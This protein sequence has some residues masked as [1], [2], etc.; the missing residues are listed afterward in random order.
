MS[1]STRPEKHSRPEKYSRKDNPFLQAQ[2]P[3]LRKPLPRAAH[4][5][6][7]GYSATPSA[8]PFIPTP[9]SSA[10][11]TKQWK[12]K[13]QALQIKTLVGLLLISMVIFSFLPEN[14][15]QKAFRRVGLGSIPGKTL[16]SVPLPVHY[17]YVSSSY[18]KRWGRQHQGIDLAARTGAPIYAASTGTVSH[19]GWEQGYGK[20]VVIDHGHGMQTRYGH[21]S[22]TLVKTGSSV[23][24]GQLIAQVGS[25]GHSTGPHLHFEVIV[26]GIRKNPAWYYHFDKAPHWYALKVKEGQN[27]LQAFSAT[28]SRWAKP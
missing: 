8:V 6:A 4:I 11:A 12:K 19:S 7:P 21:C 25:T 17:D 26:D 3:I 9:K 27:W 20:S 1:I 22:K 13:Q 5:S 23:L 16:L 15:Q 10:S 24:K 14:I 2:T 18:G 28:L